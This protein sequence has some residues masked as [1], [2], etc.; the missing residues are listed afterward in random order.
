[1]KRESQ[2][3]AIL[4][5]LLSGKT[6]TGLEAL[7]LYGSIKCSNRISELKKWGFPIQGIDVNVSGRFGDKTVKQYYL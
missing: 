6:I 3:Y 7:N 2:N 5:H 1:M 4:K